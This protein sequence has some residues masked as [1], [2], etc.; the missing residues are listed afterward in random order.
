[1]QINGKFHAI[2]SVLG[3]KET[4]EDFPIFPSLAHPLPPLITDSVYGIWHQLAN[5]RFCVNCNTRIYL[6][7]TRRNAE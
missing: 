3:Q 7:N 4:K 2:W 1:M 6:K 5:Y